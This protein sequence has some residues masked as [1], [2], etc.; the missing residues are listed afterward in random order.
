MTNDSNT[1]L[2]YLSWRKIWNED[3]LRDGSSNYG[4]TMDFVGNQPY[5]YEPWNGNNQRT[6]G[7][8]NIDTN[9]QA[10]TNSSIIIYHRTDLDQAQS[11][12]AYYISHSQLYIR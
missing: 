6:N 4:A 5:S 9:W 2:T 8:V 10:H 3:Y 7:Y 1:Q 12:E 11:D